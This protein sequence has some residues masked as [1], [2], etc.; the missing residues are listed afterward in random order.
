MPKNEEKREHEAREDAERGSD[1]LQ[2]DRAS[3]AADSLA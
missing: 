2:W 3:Q 1:I